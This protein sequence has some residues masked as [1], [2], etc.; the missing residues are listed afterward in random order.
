MGL[1]ISYMVEVFPTHVGVSHAVFT[2]HGASFRV[3]G[4]LRK[5]KLS[6]R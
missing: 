5:K 6:Y 4:S 3:R 1:D 2:G